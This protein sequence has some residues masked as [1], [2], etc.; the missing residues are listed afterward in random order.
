MVKNIIEFAK[1]DIL[2]IRTFFEIRHFQKIKLQFVYLIKQITCV[3][4][5]KPI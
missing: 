3:L 2:D 5:N 4:D 1:Y